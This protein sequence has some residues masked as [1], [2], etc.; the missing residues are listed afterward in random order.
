MFVSDEAV[1]AVSFSAA[2]ARLANLTN[3]GWLASASEHAYDEGLVGYFRVGP[4]GDVPGISKLVQVHF[5]DVVARDGA[6]LLTMRWEATGHGGGMF[7]AL[8]ADITLAPDGQYA[9]RLTLVGAYR[10]PFASLGAELDR[11]ILHRVA[12]ATVHALVSRIATAVAQPEAAARS[13]RVR[14]A[15]VR[16]KSVEGTLRAWPAGP[17]PG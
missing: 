5:R 16:R 13:T 8:D 12:T 14:S 1:L 9:T 3:G 4:L 11:R 10:P 6:A 15:E 7:P 17:E 2:Q